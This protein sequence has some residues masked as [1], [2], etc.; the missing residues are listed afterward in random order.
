MADATKIREAECRR[1]PMLLNV[2]TARHPA[3]WA[4]V[5]SVGVYGTLAEAA[6]VTTTSKAYKL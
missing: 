2:E 6:R 3:V 5:G 1:L 4:L